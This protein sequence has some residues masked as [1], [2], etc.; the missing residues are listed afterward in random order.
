MVRVD[1]SEVTADAPCLVCGKPDWCRRNANGQVHECHRRDEDVRGFTTLRTTGSGF[2]IYVTRSE[3]M[4]RTPPKKSRPKNVSKKDTRRCFK[5]RQR[6]FRAIAKRTR[7]SF[8]QASPYRSADGKLL[9]YMA[10]FETKHGKQFRPIRKSR[11]GWREGGTPDPHPLYRLPELD[12]AKCV[13]VVEGEK[14]ADALR[15]IGFDA[16]TSAFGAKSARKTD[17]TPLKGEN[18]VIIPDTDGAGRE[19]AGTVAEILLELDPPA[20]VRTVELPD[21]DEGEDIVE[22][23]EAREGVEPKRIR[24]E[25]KRLAKAAIRFRTLIEYDLSRN[26]FPMP[27]PAS[28]LGEAKDIPWVWE[29]Y[30][31]HG[32]VTLFTG[33]FKAGK[34]TLIARLV[35]ELEKGG[36]LAG[37]VLPGR[38]LVI[39]EETGAKWVERRESLGL[40]DHVDF[41]VR[42][43][44]TRPT[45]EQWQEFIDGLAQLIPVRSYALAIFDTFLSVSPCSDENDSIKMYDAIRPLH[46]LTEAG[47]AVLLVHH[48]KKGDATQGRASRGSGALPG[49]VDVIVELRRFAPAEK[50]NRRRVLTGY[51]RFDETPPEVVVELTSEGYE[52]VGTKADAGRTDRIAV[53]RTLLPDKPPGLTSVEIVEQWPQNGAIPKP[54][55]KSVRRDLKEDGAVRATGKGVRGNE[56]RFYLRTNSIP[57]SSPPIGG[58]KQSSRGDSTATRRRVG[59]PRKGKSKRLRKDAG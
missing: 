47:A 12:G 36:S 51:S 2:G 27:V 17:W 40:A 20:T 14:C 5:T 4:K 28:A 43:F 52:Q 29:G 10:R 26:E 7:A 41:I 25:I 8:I 21:L 34:S 49:F 9:F 16:T 38:A 48:P 32:Y 24:R 22:F 45:A 6:A 53:I 3:T 50:R 19:Y 15:S 44:K 33:L 18:V 55:V 35:A 23:I 46:S 31:A 13:Y 59:K 42:P 56:R 1:F 54:S 57:D 11:K 58:R 39:T 37:K 30:A